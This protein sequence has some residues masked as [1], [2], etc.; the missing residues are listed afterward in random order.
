[1]LAKYRMG[2]ASILIFLPPLNQI[3]GKPAS[4]PTII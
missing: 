4:P 2:W 3:A 1:M